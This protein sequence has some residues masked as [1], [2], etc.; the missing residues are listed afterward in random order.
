VDELASGNYLWDITDEQIAT[1]GEIC[2]QSCL[3]RER[4]QQRPDEGGAAARA[5]VLAGVTW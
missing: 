1:L 4:V 3:A 5:A 2:P